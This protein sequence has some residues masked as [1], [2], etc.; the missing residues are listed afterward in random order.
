MNNEEQETVKEFYSTLNVSTNGIVLDT[1]NYRI[2]KLLSKL[3]K[4]NRSLKQENDFLKQLYS[5]T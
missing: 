1:L 4:E 2:Y 5:G 3:E